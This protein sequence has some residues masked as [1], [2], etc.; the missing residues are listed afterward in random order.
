MLSLTTIEQ[1]EL[2]FFE[3][4]YFVINVVLF[5]SICF[6]SGYEILLGWEKENFYSGDEKLRELAKHYRALISEL[7][8][9]EFSRTFQT[10][11]TRL[12]SNSCRLQPDASSAN[13]TATKL[14]MSIALG[15]K[16]RGF[17]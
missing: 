13:L 14:A 17:L 4:C 7:T 8:D 12:D 6:V 5:L 2:N 3:I 10:S 1:F 16:G 9:H 11:D 15:W